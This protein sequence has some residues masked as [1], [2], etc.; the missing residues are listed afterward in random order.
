[1][2]IF[3]IFSGWLVAIKYCEWM[4]VYCY[5]IARVFWVVGTVCYEVAKVLYLHVLSRVFCVVAKL[6]K[7]AA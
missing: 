3:M 4:F 7:D 2:W 6:C 5:V 1:M